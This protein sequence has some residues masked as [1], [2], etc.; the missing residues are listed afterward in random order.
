[1]GTSDKVYKQEISIRNKDFDIEDLGYY[2]LYLSIGNDDFRVF[3]VSSINNTVVFLEHYRFFS[4]LSSEEIVSSLSRIY[5]NHPFLKAN[6][7]QTIYIAIR[8]GAFSLVPKEFFNPDNPQSYI[9]LSEEASENNV[10]FVNSLRTM[11]TFNIFSI[12]KAIAQWF[13]HTYPSKDLIFTHQTTAFIDSIRYGKKE[14]SEN[15]IHLLIESN[16]FILI[17]MDDEGN[18]LDFCNVFEYKTAHDF[19][20]FTLLT[21]DELRIDKDSCLAKAY[22]SISENSGIYGMLK[23]YI[24]SLQIYKESPS[25]LKFPSNFYDFPFYRYFDVLSMSVENP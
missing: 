23:R 13:Q 2:K 12:D 24:P 5:D 14:I 1:M 20:Y 17:A 22:G 11:E 4:R 9:K 19:V 6:Y 10:L 8:G 18:D 7:W 21:L 16:Y 3:I 15:Q 25:W